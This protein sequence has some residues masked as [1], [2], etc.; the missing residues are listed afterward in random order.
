VIQRSLQ[1]SVLNPHESW[2]IWLKRGQAGDF[3]HMDKYDQKLHPIEIK[4]L[5]ITLQ[6]PWQGRKMKNQAYLERMLDLIKTHDI[7]RT[8]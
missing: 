2:K 6:S 4:L 5:Y 8:L 3:G 1:V 7:L